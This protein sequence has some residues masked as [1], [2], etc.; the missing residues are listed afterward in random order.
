MMEKENTLQRVLNTEGTSPD[1]SRQIRFEN[2][3]QMISRRI[4]F[5][6]VYVIRQEST[7][8]LR[9]DSSGSNEAVS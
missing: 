3:K 2:F 4:A 8:P 9:K 6:T 1:H 5:I 7:L